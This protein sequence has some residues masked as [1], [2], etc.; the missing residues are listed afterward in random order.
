MSPAA[1]EEEQ[2]AATADEELIPALSVC[3]DNDDDDVGRCSAGAASAAHGSNIRVRCHF[4][5][6]GPKGGM[7]DDDDV[8]GSPAP[9]LDAGSKAV[10]VLL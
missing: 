6:S 3:P 10:I 2:D 5:L 9:K 4:D 1:V 8:D 7:I